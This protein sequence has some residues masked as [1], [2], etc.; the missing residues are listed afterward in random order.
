MR[1]YEAVVIGASAGGLDALKALF[2][3]LPDDFPLPIA[4]V[5]HLH[6]NT[7]DELITLMQRDIRLTV[8]YAQDKEKIKKGVLYIA[9][10]DYHLLVE[11]D[12]TFSLSV[13]EHVNYSR[14]S[15]DVLFESA[16]DAFRGHIIG[17]ILTGA[18]KDGSMGLKRIKARGGTAIVENPRS[19]QFPDMPLAAISETE[20]DY[21]LDVN[22]ITCKIDELVGAL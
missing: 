5:L 17:I 16:A 13:D 4:A 19:A 20:V 14:P 6:R 7:K 3:G 1:R 12:K 10:P 21:I 22:E 18:N 9:P 11:D 2:T 8:K 15:I